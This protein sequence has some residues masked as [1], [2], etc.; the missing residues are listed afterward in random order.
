VG[1]ERPSLDEFAAAASRRD[2]DRLRS[3]LKAAEDALDAA[4]GRLAVLEGIDRLKPRPPRWALKKRPRT[5]EAVVVAML[6][7]CHFDEIVRPEDVAGVNAYDRTIATERLKCWAHRLAELPKV[8]PAADV[9]GVVVLWGGD[10][11]TGPID[12]AHLQD[13]ADTMFGSLLYWSEQLAASFTLLAD[14]YGAVHVP[15]VVGNHGRMTMKKRSHLKARDNLDWHLAHLVA[16]LTADDARITWSIDEA[17]DAE[18]EV[19][20]RRYLLTH[21]DQA[22]GGGGIGGVWPPIMRLTARKQQRQAGLGRPFEHLFLGH[23]HQLTTGPQFTVNGS[24]VGYS[25]FSAECNFPVEPPQ[26]AVAY[27]TGDGLGWRTAIP[28]ER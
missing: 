18:F 8:G 27:L 28:C 16:R 13:A 7:D 24:V 25:G 12:V 1:D 3:Q 6:S 5:G 21:G 14:A 23:W 9:R 19:F 26:Q 15:C 10:M 17:S 22:R 11:M 2:T 4:V 20:G